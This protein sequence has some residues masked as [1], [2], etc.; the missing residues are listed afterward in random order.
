M[1]LSPNNLLL[2]PIPGQGE[3]APVEPSDTN[4]TAS[5]LYPPECAPEAEQILVNASLAVAVKLFPEGIGDAIV[6]HSKSSNMVASISMSF[7]NALLKERIGC[8][9]A[10][11][12]SHEKAPRFIQALFKVDLE[13]R[14][15]LR[16]VCLPDGAEIVPNPHFTFRQCQRNA[17]LTIFGPEVSN[18]IFASPGYQEEERQYR[19]KTESVW[20]VVSQGAEESVVINLSLGL[21]EGT[22]ISEKLFPRLQ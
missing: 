15:G 16:Y 22:Q 10:I 8:H 2:N 9:M 21:W 1:T 14:A 6:R 19:F 17:I 7:P 5:A 12:L 18:A 20:G 11:E 13:T 4:H 3:H